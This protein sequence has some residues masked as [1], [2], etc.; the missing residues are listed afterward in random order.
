MPT[1]LRS[2]MAVLPALVLSVA[3]KCPLCLVAYGG[4]WGITSLPLSSF[5]LYLAWLP[6]AIWA[7]L[8]LVL[9]AIGR[10][11]RS[12][13]HRWPFWLAFCGAALVMAGRFWLQDN[14]LLGL[15]LTLLLG[16][17]FAP[18][19]QAAVCSCDGATP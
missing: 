9:L 17:T 14:L 10:Q 18:G 3:P 12:R 8:A 16:A 13:G 1:I 5:G 7:A 4:L 2:R 11:C 6:L 19:R 15:G